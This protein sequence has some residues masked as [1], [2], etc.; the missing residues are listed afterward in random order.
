MAPGT[1]NAMSSPAVNSTRYGMRW[2]SSITFTKPNWMKRPLLAAPDPRA[3]LAQL[4]EKRDPL[5][6]E[7]AH[8]IVETGAQSA[9]TAVNRVLAALQRDTGERA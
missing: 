3:V 6:R 4:L 9:A 2:I 1:F 8:V 5:Y 7:A